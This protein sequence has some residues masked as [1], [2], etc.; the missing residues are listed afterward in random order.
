M[1]NQTPIIEVSFE[2]IYNMLMAEIEPELMT[3]N[4]SDLD[5][6]YAGESEKNKKKRLKGYKK[7]FIK[8]N[9][10]YDKLMQIWHKECVKGK[11]EMDLE[12]LKLKS[13]E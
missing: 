13:A 11:S 5:E 1:P 12:D 4:M 6:K 10:N 8:F 3:N 7:A 2:D 9:K